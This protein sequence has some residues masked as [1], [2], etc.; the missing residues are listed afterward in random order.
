LNRFLSHDDV[1]QVVMLER[2]VSRLAEGVARHVELDAPLVS[3]TVA[4]L[5]LPMTA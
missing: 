4:K 3:W 1:A 5:A 2:L